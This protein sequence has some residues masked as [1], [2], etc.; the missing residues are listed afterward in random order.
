MIAIIINICY[1]ADSHDKSS[2][3]QPNAQK[4][5]YQ[6]YPHTIGDRVF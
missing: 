5:L 1:I 2:E 3:R 6:H 4:T